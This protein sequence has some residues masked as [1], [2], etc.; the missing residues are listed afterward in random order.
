[1][2]LLD[3]ASDA[4]SGLR[5][6]VEKI[7]SLQPDVVFVYTYTATEKEAAERLAALGVPIVIASDYLE[8]TPLGMAEWIKF[9]ALFLGE[10]KKAEIF[11][12]EY[13]SDIIA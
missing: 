8:E 1:M 7:L 10:E 4:G 13:Q 5:I 6:D 3:V 12:E 11:L 2:N 9:V